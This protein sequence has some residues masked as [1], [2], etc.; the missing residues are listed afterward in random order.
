MKTLRLATRGSDL[1][2]TQSRTIAAALEDSRGIKTELVI[3]K[4]IGDRVLDVPLEQVG[5]IGLFTKEVQQ[6]LFDGRADYAVHSLKDLPAEQVSGLA[7]AAVPA[8][9]DARDCLLIRP[10]AYDPKR[11]PLP[12]QVGSIVG[13][14]AA[15]RSALLADLVPDAQVKLLRGNVPTRVEKLR[16]GHYDAIVL[17]AA[18]I[19]RLELDLNGLV[20]VSMEHADWPGAPG[21]GALAIECRSDD[22]ET[23]SALAPL[24]IADDAALVN[25]ERALLRALGGGCSLPLG[26]SAVMQG[27]RID[28]QAALG[29]QDHDPAGTPLRRCHLCGT[30]AAKLVQQAVSTLTGQEAAL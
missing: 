7:C 2:L 20:V 13:T 23:L 26:A 28:L 22:S 24:H 19:N 16:Q 10:Q 14:S 17:A 29:P 9:Q 11:S 30:D 12:L 8:R 4:T 25:V 5:G 27:D 1:A 3:I 21:Q 6:A 18:G 15:R